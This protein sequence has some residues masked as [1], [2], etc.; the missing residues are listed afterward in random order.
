MLSQSVQEALN[1]QIN[2]EFASAYTYLAAAAHFEAVSLTGFATWMRRQYEEELT[3]ALRLFDHMLDRNGRVK[4]DAI[5]QPKAR[6]SSA[7]EAFETA[8]EHEQKVTAAI[9]NLYALAKNEKDYATEVM[10]EWF[11]REQVEEEKTV[12]LIVDQLKMAGDESAALLM[13][14]Q[15]YGQRGPDTMSEEE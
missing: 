7:L 5:A 9:H 13:L 6:F 10:L 11:I 14:D 15:K 3:H 1:N 2:L 8:L 12:S 4:L